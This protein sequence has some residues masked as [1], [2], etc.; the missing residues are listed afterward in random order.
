V[1]FIPFAFSFAFAPFTFY[2]ILYV[3]FSIIAQYQH[4][5]YAYHL[6]DLIGR[7]DQLKE[8]A[9]SLASYAA[10]LGLLGLLWIVIIYAFVVWGFW[11]FPDDFLALGT[12]NMAVAG[13]NISG[14]CDS[15]WL[16]FYYHLTWTVRQGGGIA[17][18][19]VPVGQF[20][21]Y[22]PMYSLGHF[23]VRVVYDLL[24]WIICSII[25]VAIVTGIIIDAFG[26]SRDRRKEVEEDQA[27]K[28]FICG[29]ENSRFETKRPKDKHDTRHYGFAWHLEKEHNQWN[30]VYFLA[31]LSLKDPNEYTGSESYVAALVNSQLTDFFPMDRSLMLEA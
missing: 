30:Y 17:D 11:G 20:W 8:V 19:L 1:R 26:A 12:S 31:H 28:C 24:F 23:Y 13:D 7:S 27:G 16:C 3:A 29:I 15:P 4:A 2:Q 25:M 21:Y 14:D 5:F 10:S 9:A 18:A 22:P 6:L